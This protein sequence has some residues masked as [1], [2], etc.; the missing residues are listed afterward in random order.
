MDKRSDKKNRGGKIKIK[1]LFANTH[2]LDSFMRASNVTSLL[3][4]SVCFLS[5][6]WQTKEKYTNLFD[7]KFGMVTHA[8]KHHKGRPFGGLQMIANPNLKPRPLSK[9]EN[10][11][12][13]EIRGLSIIG[14]YF[15][16]SC[17]LD[18]MILEL[19]F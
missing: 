12:A 11:L 7:N 2:G 5:E 18:S 15:A 3:K 9:G 17:D 6:T 10:H 8:N 1:V 4:S 19:T 13:L 16:P 14:C